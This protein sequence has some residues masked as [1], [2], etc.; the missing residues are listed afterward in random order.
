MG[1][2]RSSDLGMSLVIDWIIING[3]LAALGALIAMAHPL[4]IITAFLAA[5]LTSLNPM[6]G[7]GMVTAG[8]E[9]YLRK[10]K[11]GDFGSLRKDASSL[12]GWWSNQVTRILLIFI[13]SSFGSAV[14]TYL[15]GFRIYGKLATG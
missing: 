2:S 3:G 8:M 6:V 9:T 10:P 13:L 1:F 7:A 12:K 14:G 4:T 5:P 11:V 15:A